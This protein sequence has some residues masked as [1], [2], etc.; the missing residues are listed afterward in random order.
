MYPF[1]HT[2]YARKHLQ[3]TKSYIINNQF[4]TQRLVRMPPQ[5]GIFLAS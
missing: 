5:G 1:D 2:F 3:E 4:F